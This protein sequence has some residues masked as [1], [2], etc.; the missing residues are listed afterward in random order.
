MIV[1]KIGELIGFRRPI[2]PVLIFPAV[3]PPGLYSGVLYSSERVISAV[4]NI[5]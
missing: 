3:A 2:N 5:F 4:S 1:L